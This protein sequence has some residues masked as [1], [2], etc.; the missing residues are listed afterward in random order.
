[1]SRA[2]G[3]NR[4]S[5]LLTKNIEITGTNRRSNKCSALGGMLPPKKNYKFFKGDVF[6]FLTKPL[7]GDPICIS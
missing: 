7:M 5:N 6:F 3:A 1:M 2:D 4:I